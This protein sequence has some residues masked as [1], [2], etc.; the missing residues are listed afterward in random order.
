[1]QIT[2][3]SYLTAGISLTAATALALTPIAIPAN[4]RA[5]TVPK[6][7]TADV[8]LAVTPSD[9]IEF[10]DNLQSEIAAFNAAVAQL[11]LIPSQSVVDG[12]QAAI[13]LNNDIYNTLISST[14]NLTLQALFETLQISTDNSLRYVRDAVGYNGEVVVYSHEEIADLLSGIVTGSMSN[15]LAAVVGVLNDPL[16]FSNYANLVNSGI[17]S[18]ALLGNNSG[19]IVRSATDIPFE[20]TYTQLHL[21]QSEINNAFRTVSGLVNVGAMATGS[22][23]IQAVAVA[24]E[25]ITLLPAQLVVNAPFSLA[26]NTIGAVDEGLTAILDGIVGYD[27][28]DG[29]RAPGLITIASTV[30]QIAVTQ[31]GLNPLDPQ[32]YLEAGGALIA[33]GFDSFNL[34]VDTVGSVARVP[35]NFVYNLFTPEPGTESLTFSVIRMNDLI[36]NSIAGVLFELGLPDD[37]VNVPRVIATQINNVITAGANLVVG[38]VEIADTVIGETTSFLITV[39]NDIENALFGARPPQQEENFSALAAAADESDS[40]PAD[41]RSGDVVLAVDDQ[42]DEPVEEVAEEETPVEAEAPV[43]EVP[44]DED[45]DD[46]EP[47]DEE[48][49]ADEEPAE[50]DT[51]ADDEATD[52]APADDAG[53]DEGAD[54]TSGSDDT[55][56][57]KSDTASTSDSSDSE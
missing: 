4:E 6:V 32:R 11:A 18:A 57:E 29:L 14:D 8:Q 37:I 34:T 28:G 42:T 2:A 25:S 23:L 24:V 13:D 7:T 35:G 30:L 9:V 45:V 19:E 17:A 53:A 50:D 27:A 10:F 21:A 56:S 43:E 33:G 15:V 41:N 40:K 36:A 55:K 46:T 31:I 39:S 12:L 5:I 54:D 38:G 48:E 20:L 1:M 47:V 22:Q 26:N 51:A 52:D 44:S 49:P 16:T 3:R